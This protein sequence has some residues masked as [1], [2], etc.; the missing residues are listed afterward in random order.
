MLML[1]KRLRITRGGQISVP[2]ELR[3]RWGGSVVTLE[4]RG[5]HAVIRPAP[6]D[7]ITAARGAL[8][9]LAGGATSDD[10]RREARA[11]DAE[12]DERRR[13]EA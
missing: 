13:G 7:P 6:D 5:D 1:M 10:M 2:A 3:H 12:L 11:E 8:K 9:H 4:D